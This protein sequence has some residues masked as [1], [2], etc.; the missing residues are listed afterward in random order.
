[1]VWQG[2]SETCLYCHTWEKKEEIENSPFYLQI[3]IPFN[4]LHYS[5]FKVNVYKIIYNFASLF[6]FQLKSEN[7][8]LYKK[9]SISLCTHLSRLGTIGSTWGRRNIDWRRSTFGNRRCCLKLEYKLVFFVFRYIPFDH[10]ELLHS[11]AFLRVSPALHYH[12][13]GKEIKRKMNWI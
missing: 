6:Y 12:F 1:M 13:L 11:F 3:Q 2:S 4:L 7:H 8:Y 5:L 10:S 9:L